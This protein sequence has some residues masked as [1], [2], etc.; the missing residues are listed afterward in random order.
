M[1]KLFSAILIA[2]FT[3]TF[4]SI[5]LAEEGSFEEQNGDVYWIVSYQAIIE[6][7]DWGPGATR[8]ILEL[9]EAV[10]PDEVNDADFT[11]TVTRQPGFLMSLGGW[12]GETVDV[13]RPI[14]NA[15]ASDENGEAIT[16]ASRFV[17]LELLVNPDNGNPFTFVLSPMG[18]RWADSHEHTITWLGESFTPNRTGE[19]RPITD[20]FDLNGEFTLGEQTLFYAHYAPPQA[21]TSDRPLIIWL[22]G[23]GEGN[24]NNT[25]NPEI[26]LLGNRVTQLAASEIQSIMGGAHVFVPTTPSA[27]MAGTDLWQGPETGY[28]SNYEATLLALIDHFIANTSGI[29]TTRIYIGGC[30]NGGYMVMRMLLERPNLY[31]AAFPICLGYHQDWFD[32]QKMESIA[33][34]PI[35][36]IHDVRDNTLNALHAIRVYEELIAAGA[37]N[38]RL[39]LTDGIYTMIDGEHWYHSPHWSWIPV[40]N[41]S[42]N[43]V[44]TSYSDLNRSEDGNVIVDDPGYFEESELDYTIFE[45]I[46]LQS[47]EVEVLPLEVIEEQAIEEMVIEEQAIEEQAIEEPAVVV[48]ENQEIR[49]VNTHALNV[50]AGGGMNHDIIGHVHHGDE[51][52][53]LESLGNGWVRIIFNNLSGFVH[54]SFLN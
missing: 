30:S 1:K 38:V 13:D 43:T 11:V 32:A 9:N 16:S 23:A 7:F 46:S 19:I 50:R 36:M 33:H 4:S 54:E 41:N 31:A 39:T 14:L 49:T 53:I 27:W 52:L 20:L 34:I 21:A 24:V 17:T 2:M 5:A 3:L 18:N 29:D 25:V 47:I 28:V 42:I 12:D 26:A 35:W 44:T 45:W 51:L 6:G 15:F 10:S 8:L 40:L 48:S 37:T 22:H